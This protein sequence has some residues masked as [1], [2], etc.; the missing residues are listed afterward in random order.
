MEIESKR[1]NPEDETLESG[2]DSIIG[3]QGLIKLTLIN[4]R[5]HRI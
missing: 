4:F 3:K 5:L 1:Q 2:D